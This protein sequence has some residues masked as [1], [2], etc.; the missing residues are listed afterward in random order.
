MAFDCSELY[1]T[2][3]MYKSLIQ[4][5]SQVLDY[6]HFLLFTIRL[7]HVEDDSLIENS[8]KCALIRHGDYNLDHIIAQNVLRDLKL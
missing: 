2:G 3:T 8:Y 7:V 1:T 5:E 4:N 6:C